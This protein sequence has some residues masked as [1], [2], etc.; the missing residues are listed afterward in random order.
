MKTNPDET[1]RVA[2][3]IKEISD[4]VFEV[5]GDYDVA[6]LIQAQTMEELNKKIDYIRSLPAILNTN[7]LI[8]LKG[9]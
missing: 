8:K 1:R 9:D 7:T 2:T 4:R 3:K 5:S 6:A